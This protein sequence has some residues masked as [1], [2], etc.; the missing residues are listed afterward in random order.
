MRMS[1]VGELSITGKPPHVASASIH[2][3]AALRQYL[4]N[5][6]Q[7]V[8]PERYRP[9]KTSTLQAD[10]RPAARYDKLRINNLLVAHLK[11]GKQ[12]S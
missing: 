1:I 6:R 10:A 8:R 2:S 12:G 7:L 3:Y 4:G 11:D 9:G 5:L